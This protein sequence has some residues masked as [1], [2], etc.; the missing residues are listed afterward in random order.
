M[1]TEKWLAKNCDNLTGKRVVITGAT[2]G[3]GREISFMF[4]K[5]GA[6]LTLACRNLELAEK[7]KIEIENEVKNAKIDIVWLDLINLKSVKNCVNLLKKYKGIDILVNNAA[8]Y[9]VPIKTC[10][11]GFNNVFNINF[12]NSYYLTKQLLPELEKK[13]N[14]LCI[15]VGS[16][17]HNYSKI[18]ENDIDFS[19]RKKQRLI[20][21][22]S[23]R[24]LM[25]S[26]FELFKN[27][28][29][30]LSV[31]HPGITFT[32]MTSHYHKSINWLVKFGVRVVFPPAKI[33]ARNVMFALK[34]SA[35]NQEWIG[36]AI[37]NIWGNPKIKK[38]KTFSEEE[39]Q[40][41]FEI[42]EE[43]YSKM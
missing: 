18:D 32:S 40:K 38:L 42:A 35:Q 14:S 25:Y 4:A 17:A 10:E 16:I 29:S 9:N 5:L 19:S 22:N 21:G 23:K 7:L 2:G 26:L 3:L 30:R 15:T 12:V 28:S 20:Y 41:I 11:N 39:S 13:E 43:I 24:F 34:N 36:P 33:A 31:A 1:K 37:F 27:S 6:N 8:V